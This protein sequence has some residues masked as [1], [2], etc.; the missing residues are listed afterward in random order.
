MNATFEH[1]PDTYYKKLA[2]VVVFVFSMLKVISGALIEL[3][4]DEVYYTLFARHLSASYFDHP[5]LTGW[6]IYLSTLGNILETEL[7]VRFFPILLSG[8]SAWFLFK[9]MQNLV[10]AQAGFYCVLLFLSS[11]YFTVISGLFILPDAPL[12]FFSILSLYLALPPLL[13]NKPTTRQRNMFILAGLM[14]GIAALGKYTALFLWA[15]YGLYALFINRKWWGYWQWYA[16]G[17]VF[18]VCLTPVLLWNIEHHFISFTFHGDRVSRLNQ[19][20]DFITFGR[21]FGGQTVYQGIVNFVLG[22]VA[23]IWLYKT[24]AWKKTL[25]L[26][27]LFLSLPLIIGFSYSS[28]LR[29]TLPHWSGPAFI[30]INIVIAMFLAENK[31]WVKWLYVSVV[32]NGIVI[33]LASAQIK[34]GFLNIAPKYGQVVDTRLGNDDFTM[35]M[36]GWKQFGRKF[37]NLVQSDTTQGFDTDDAFVVTNKWFPAGHIEFY[38]TRPYDYNFIPFGNITDLHHYI[39]TYPNLNNQIG[40]N[41]YYITYSQ[42]FIPPDYLQSAFDTILSPDTVTI[43]RLGKPVKFYYV[44]R[45]KKYNGLYPVSDFVT[46]KN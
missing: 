23:F 28:L 4:N 24:K 43:T 11:L 41:A 6:L 5:P 14:A 45:L 18:L 29:T 38:V 37:D 35:D 31:Q 40:Q 32:L 1:K 36:Y 25:V 46:N 21:F 2:L 44:Y 12:V 16:S 39:Y 34:T 20:P 13:A 22:T 15:G 10:S 33:I 9:L 30:G 7:A 42:K 19:F 26:L 27:L 8:L 3:G 17:F